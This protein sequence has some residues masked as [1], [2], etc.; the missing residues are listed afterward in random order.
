ML[1][2]HFAH[3]RGLHSPAAPAALGILAGLVAMLHERHWSRPRRALLQLLS[4]IR[5]GLA[6]I[7]ELSRIGGGMA[8][9]IP[10]IQ[11]LLRELREQKLAVAQ[12]RHEMSQRVA[13]RTDALER[14]IGS[15]R[16]QMARDALTG[17]FNRRVLDRCLP[18]MLARCTAARL[19]LSV[20]MIDVDNFKPLNDTLG[21]TAG[22]ELLR[23]IGRIIRSGIRGQDAAFRVGGDEFVILLPGAGPQVAAALSARLDQLV[24]ALTKPLHLA[25]RPRLSIGA[26]SLSQ[27]P[28][29]QASELIAQADQRSYQ[30]K[31]ARKTQAQRPPAVVLAGGPPIRQAN[32]GDAAEAMQSIS[33]FTTPPRQRNSVVRAGNG[34]VKYSR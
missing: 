33:N 10:A 32:H 26:A 16:Q 14:R 20:L 29:A 24:D 9:L 21:H 34:S 8:P 11:Q 28:D 27:F 31:A 30:T 3:P 12:A 19:D 17:V 13:N 25:H 5:A 6:P 7:E 15:L 2:S 22:D 4:E 23:D 1:W 18:E